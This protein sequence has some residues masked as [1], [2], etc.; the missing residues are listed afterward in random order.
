[1]RFGNAVLQCFP[2]LKEK[3]MDR[4]ADTWGKRKNGNSKWETLREVLVTAAVEIIQKESRRKKMI[5]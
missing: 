2:D 4:K 3:Y 5:R 1:M